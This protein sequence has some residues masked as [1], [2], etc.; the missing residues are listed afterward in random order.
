MRWARTNATSYRRRLVATA[1]AAV[2]AVPLA[3]SAAADGAPTGTTLRPAKIDRGKNTDLLHTQGKVIVDGDTRVR[4]SQGRRLR[5]LGRSGRAYVA[6][7]MDRSYRNWRLLRL[8]H[9]GGT[10]L[11]ARGKGD[12]PEPHLSDDGSHVVLVRVGNRRTRLTVVDTRNGHVLRDRRFPT[13]ID[14]QDYGSRRMVLSEWTNRSRTFWWNPHTNRR[15]RISGQPAYIADIS[16]DR[17]GLFISEVPRSCQRVVRLS[18]PA[19]NLWRSCKNRAFEFS[20]NGRRMVTSHILSDGP[21]PSR[22]QVRGTHGKLFATYRA[23]WF[24]FIVWE[25]RRSVLLETAGTK[26]TAAVRCAP[27]ARCERASKVFRNPGRDPYFPPAMH[28]GFPARP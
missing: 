20:P 6:V 14:V 7:T 5:L 12:V 2:L 17:V 18:R 10:S 9:T 27:P 3:A 19:A 25:N 11:I 4:I 16:A 15:V 24:G 28:W 23:E 22:L 21:G 26:Y 13:Y 8:N 1:A